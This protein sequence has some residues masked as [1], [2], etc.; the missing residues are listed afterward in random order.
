VGP[1]CVAL[2]FVLL[3]KGLAVEYYCIQGVLSESADELTYLLT[4]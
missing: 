4:P 3:C 1:G 2:S